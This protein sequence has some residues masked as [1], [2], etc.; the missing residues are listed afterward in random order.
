MQKEQNDKLY[1]QDKQNENVEQ[2]MAE[3]KPLVSK[4]AR[5]YFLYGGELDDL[6]QE[7][8]I[9]LYKAIKD[10]DDKKEASFKTFANL[11][12]TRQIQTAIRNANSKKNIMFLEILDNSDKNFDIATNRENPESKLIENQ[13]YQNFVAEINQK[14]SKKEL[15]ILNAYLEGYSYDQIAKK[16][17]IERKS[18]NNALVRIRTKLSH[19]LQKND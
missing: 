2:I 4:I 15:D 7:G 16:L 9:G 10:F 11:C 8:M 6:M 3:Y 14:L 17:D 5:R 18:V 19:F 12:I 1:Q 13:S